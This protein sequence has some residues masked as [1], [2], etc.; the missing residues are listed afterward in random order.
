[1][2][3]YCDCHDC[4]NDGIYWYNGANICEEHDKYMKFIYDNEITNENL[5]NFMLTNYINENVNYSF[6]NKINKDLWNTFT[7]TGVY[8]YILKTKNIIW[9][10]YI[11]FK[12][13]KNIEI[14]FTTKN[15]K[16]LDENIYELFDEHDISTN[17][18][19]IGCFLY[20][21]DN[22]NDSSDLYGLIYTLF[23]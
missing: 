20:D 9:D 2:E 8:S 1:M 7:N 15:Y 3:N 17:D 14:Y 16:N 13:I 21:N 10:V 12:D 11:E 22:L 4:I 5:A 19:F 6:D 23:Q 18:I